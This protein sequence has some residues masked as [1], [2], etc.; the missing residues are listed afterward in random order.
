MDDEIKLP[1]IFTLKSDKYSS[2]IWEHPGWN[3][4]IRLIYFKGVYPPL[5][6][7]QFL[8]CSRSELCLILD[9]IFIK[10]AEHE[11]KTDPYII[12]HIDISGYHRVGTVKNIDRA[13]RFF[14]I[15]SKQSGNN[16]CSLYGPDDKRAQ[17]TVPLEQ[18]GLPLIL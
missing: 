2:D 7:E 12:R 17:E 6:S 1:S 9:K 16:Q 18:S 8:H 14:N 11:I 4:R 10:N 15:I 13:R 5:T 3:A